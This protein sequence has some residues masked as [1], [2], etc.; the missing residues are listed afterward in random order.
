MRDA[1]TVNLRLKL[2]YFPN[3]DRV[4][5]LQRVEVAPPCGPFVPLLVQH[6]TKNPTTTTYGPAM[7]HSW[8]LHPLQLHWEQGL[9]V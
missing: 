7:E 8:G 9:H 1:D 3:L 4:S 5:R 6:G 2:A